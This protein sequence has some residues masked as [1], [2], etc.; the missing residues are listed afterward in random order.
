MLSFPL[1]PPFVL[2]VWKNSAH[3]IWIEELA[4]HQRRGPKGVLFTYCNIST[5][6]STRSPTDSIRSMTRDVVY[7]SI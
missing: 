3:G 7:L 1:H 6:Y 2:S 5:L 4:C